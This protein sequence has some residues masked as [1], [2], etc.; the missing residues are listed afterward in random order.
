MLIIGDYNNQH[1]IKIKKARR[2]KKEWIDVLIFIGKNGAAT[3]A[4]VIEYARSAGISIKE[5]SLR[6]QFGSY[7]DSGFLDRIGP[8]K[9]RLTESGAAKCGYTGK[10][11][12]GDVLAS[13]DSIERPAVSRFRRDLLGGTSSVL[14]YEKGASG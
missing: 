13:P 12:S 2:L 6:G 11:E 10:A 5:D 4:D 3:Y 9:F 8:G 1:P 7:V 14:H